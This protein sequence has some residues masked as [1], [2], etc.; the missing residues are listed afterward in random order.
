MVRVVDVE[1][2]DGIYRRAIHTLCFLGSP[3]EGENSRPDES[4]VREEYVPA[5]T[6]D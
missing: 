4:P 3:D 1:T 2:I 5:K 6:K